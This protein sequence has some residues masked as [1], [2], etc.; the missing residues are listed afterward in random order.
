MSEAETFRRLGYI[1][2][3]GYGPQ[4]DFTLEQWLRAREVVS[5]NKN[6][7]LHACGMSRNMAVMK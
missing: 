3:T 4:S 6:K 7:V 1:A 5:K 2:Y